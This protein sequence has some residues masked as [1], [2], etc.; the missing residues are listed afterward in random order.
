[1]MQLNSKVDNFAKEMR[2]LPSFSVVLIND[3]LLNEWKKT[4]QNSNRCM[5]S[6]DT[7]YNLGDFYVSTVVA[8][9]IL[10]EGDP[11][12]PIATLLHH[13]RDEKSHKLLLDALK[14]KAPMV[15]SDRVVIVTDR[16][17]FELPYRM[18][19]IFFVGIISKLM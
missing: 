11:G 7:T 12:Y 14:D 3:L 2:C 9:H 17:K 5:L 18:P 10:F 1:M 13:K 16:E 4:Y 19:I 8:R 6:Y 15:N